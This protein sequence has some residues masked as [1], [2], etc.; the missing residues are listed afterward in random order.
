MISSKTGVDLNQPITC[1][2]AIIVR[3]RIY[4]RP[5]FCTGLTCWWHVFISSLLVAAD[6]QVFSSSSCLIRLSI[7]LSCSALRWSKLAG[8]LAEEPTPAVMMTRH[9]AAKY[10]NAAFNVSSFIE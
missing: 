5:D 4:S 9:P 6:M 7:R 10:L 3:V 8:V 2:L 1:S